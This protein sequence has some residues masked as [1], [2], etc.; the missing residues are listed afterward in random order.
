MDLIWRTMSGRAWDKKKK[1][2]S[3]CFLIK[4]LVRQIWPGCHCWL[5][6]F[7]HVFIKTERDGGNLSIVSDPCRVVHRAKE[8]VWFQGPS[9]ALI[10]GITYATQ[11]Q[12]CIYKIFRKAWGFK[13][14]D[15]SFNCLFT[16]YYAVSSLDAKK[17]SQK[18]DAAFQQ[19]CFHFFLNVTPSGL[20]LDR[21]FNWIVQKL[22]ALFRWEVCTWRVWHFALVLVLLWNKVSLKQI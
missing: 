19:T 2:R 20:N 6:C 22:S 17:L 4:K 18:E 8:R 10:F 14:E 11:T 16:W 21:T 15:I 9:R 5:M 7:I 12:I 1:K 13:R 3:H